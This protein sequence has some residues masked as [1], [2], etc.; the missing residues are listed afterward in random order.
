MFCSVQQ[1][2]GPPCVFL[3]VGFKYVTC[4]LACC[5]IPEV[6]LC[7]VIVSLYVSAVCVCVCVRVAHRVHASINHTATWSLYFS[8]RHKPS[9]IML[10]N[11]QTANGVMLV[12]A[13]EQTTQKRIIS[14]HQ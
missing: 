13:P 9:I 12:L 3:Y 1:S 5:I 2:S 7:V 6:M 4:L 10:R 8:S 11:K 14:Q